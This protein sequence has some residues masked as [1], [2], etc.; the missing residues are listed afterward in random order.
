MGW[1]THRG[2]LPKNIPST[3]DIRITA[4]EVSTKRCDET[5]GRFR[6][7]LEVEGVNC[8][9][10]VSLLTVFRADEKISAFLVIK[11]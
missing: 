10:V 5:Q 8:S 4:G 9:F 6:I 3:Y 2:G 7:T 11:R 1:E